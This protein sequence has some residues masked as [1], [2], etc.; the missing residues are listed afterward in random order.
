LCL[1]N[2]DADWGI[3]GHNLKK[4]IDPDNDEALAATVHGKK[5]PAQLCF[6]SPEL[7]RRTESYI[8]DNFGEQSSIRIVIAP[9][10]LQWAC[11]CPECSRLGNTEKNAT[12]AVAH[13]A[14][15]LAKRFP[16]HQFY[17]LSYLSTQS[18]PQTPLPH[19]VGTIISAMSLPFKLVDDEP[20]TNSC[21]ARQLM[22][23]QHVTDRLF[24]WDYINNFDDYLTPFPILRVAAQRLQLFK[25][26]KVS[27]VFLNGSGYQYASFNDLKTAVLASLLQ[28]PRRSISRLV[29]EF[30]AKAYPVSC[31]WLYD[32]YMKLEEEFPRNKKFNLYM[33]SADLKRLYFRASW[34]F[35]FYEG[36]NTFI[37]QAAEPERTN[38][39]H[40][41]TALSYQLLEISRMY[42]MRSNFRY[43][44]IKELLTDGIIQSY[45]EAGETIHDYLTEWEH[46]MSASDVTPNLLAG[47]M[48]K[49]VLPD[50]EDAVPNSSELLSLTDGV[51]G[52]PGNY[53][54]GWVIFPATTV[55]LNFSVSDIIESGTLKLSFLQMPRHHI[56]A[57]VEMEIY[58]NG[59]LCQTVSLSSFDKEEPSSDGHSRMLKKS[60]PLSMD[61]VSHLTIRLK[62]SKKGEMA[63]DEIAFVR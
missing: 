12:P 13:F 14:E 56:Y 4:V 6:S 28:N 34:F 24:V 20:D 2:F 46:Y 44:A 52:F 60:I 42:N 61:E 50:G 10:D 57:P 25:R 23:W 39:R 32:Y 15:Q 53:H 1:N 58:Q 30:L 7:Y 38:L 55:D 62:G 48:P 29:K 21:F 18:P 47:V 5:E 11:T 8:V 22:Q 43:D 26:L 51:H 45:S 36:L 33:G 40:L 17:I 41:Q 49:V 3:W 35:D 54:C 16:A 37:E 59:T 19:N 31:D 9:T 27:G 63:I